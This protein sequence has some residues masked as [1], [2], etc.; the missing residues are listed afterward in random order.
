[1]PAGIGRRGRIARASP[2]G[3]GR[4]MRPF[5]I[6]ERGQQ[7]RLICSGGTTWGGTPL[8]I[9]ARLTLLTVRWTV[10]NGAACHCRHNANILPRSKCSV[11]TRFCAARL[12]L[13][14][15]LKRCHLPQEGG[16]VSVPTQCQY[17]TTL[18]QFRKRTLLHRS[19]NICHSSLKFWMNSRTQTAKNSQ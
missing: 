17:S 14:S 1:M 9:I 16:P 19:N 4:S 13:P 15:P 18:Q 7:F 12:L 3:K 8:T 2:M 10:N 5:P 6:N 11:N